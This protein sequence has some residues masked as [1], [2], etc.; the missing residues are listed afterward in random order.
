MYTKQLQHST[1][2]PWLLT[3]MALLSLCW[4]TLAW[5]ID[6]P[7]AL[8]DTLKYSGCQSHR[9]IKSRLYSRG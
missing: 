9:A 5:A 2:N 3:T 6:I 8:L 4:A 7:P 1:K